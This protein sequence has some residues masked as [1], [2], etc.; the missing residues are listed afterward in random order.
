MVGAIELAKLA[1][2]ME[3]RGPQAVDDVDPLQQFLSAS[4][5]LRRILDALQG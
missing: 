4:A 5:R 1:G 3:E 2:A